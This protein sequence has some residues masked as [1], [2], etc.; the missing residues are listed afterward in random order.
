MVLSIESKST[1]VPGMN[2]LAWSLSFPTVVGW[3]LLKQIFGIVLIGISLILIFH[4]R[5][6]FL[7]R[8]KKHNSLE[9][10]DF[11][12]TLVVAPRSFITQSEAI[13][14]NLIQLTVQDSYLI[15][16][17]LPLGQIIAFTEHDKA[18]KQLFMR[19]AQKVIV[20]IAL[21][22]PGTLSPALI[23]LWDD[24]QKGADQKHRA[25][26]LVGTVCREASLPVIWLQLGV[27][28]TVDELTKLF[29][30]DEEE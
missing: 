4:L 25:R 18:S 3:P 21:V 1:T 23:V 14:F 10:L 16:A 12:K 8:D 7:L 26:Q 30:L 22:H 20:D 28:Y 24:A 29:G 9:T 27:P 11:P 15:F 5:R 17:K 13:L 6:S 19:T 2:I